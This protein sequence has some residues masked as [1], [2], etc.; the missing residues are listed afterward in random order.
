[1]KQL[2]S[3]FPSILIPQIQSGSVKVSVNGTEL[4][5]V[6]CDYNNFEIDIADEKA[7]KKHASIIPRKLRH[8]KVLHELSAL[9]DR[10][11]ISVSINDDSGLIIKV[12]KGAKS[13]LGNVH[14]KL[15]RIRRIF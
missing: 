10:N 2:K 6:K 1:M 8:L 15:T 3:K 13:V 11:G 9:L 4:V 12:G 14:I 7:V 5:T